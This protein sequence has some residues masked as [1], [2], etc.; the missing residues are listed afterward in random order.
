PELG[1]PTVVEY[2]RAHKT[3]SYLGD[4]GYPVADLVS[5]HGFEKADAELLYAAESE[6]ALARLSDRF[7]NEWQRLAILGMAVGD[8]IQKIRLDLGFDVPKPEPERDAPLA[9]A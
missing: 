2:V 3:R 4:H 5:G 6:D 8:T 1:A 7:E 9:D